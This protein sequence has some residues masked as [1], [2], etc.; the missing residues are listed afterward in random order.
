MLANS[1]ESVHDFDIIHDFGGKA[2]P[3]DAQLFTKQHVPAL[4]SVPLPGFSLLPP[5]GEGSIQ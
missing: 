1:G 2:Q 3:N 5:A 4:V